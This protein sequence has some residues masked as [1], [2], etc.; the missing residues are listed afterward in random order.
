MLKKIFLFLSL[1]IFNNISA[2]EEFDVYSNALKF[3]N[4]KEYATAYSLFKSISGDVTFEEQKRINS[5]YYTAECLVQLEQFDGAAIVYEFLITEYPFS[6]FCEDALY[7]LGIIYFNRAE[8]RRARERLTIFLNS[9]PNSINYGSA[10]YWIAES[11][12]AENRF[13][14]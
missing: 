5:Y 11:F 13:C 7:K 8:H 1:L 9:Y 3:F 10:L 14:N 4:N 6:N 12:A 2:I